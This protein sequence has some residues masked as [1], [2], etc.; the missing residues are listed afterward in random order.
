MSEDKELTIYEA[1]KAAGVPLDSHESDLYALV[2]PESTRIVE[3]YRFRSNVT[4]FV[5]Q[6]DKKRWYDIPFAYLPFWEKKS[7]GGEVIG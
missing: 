3:A 1:L 5:S 4:T 6:I 7:K 2:T